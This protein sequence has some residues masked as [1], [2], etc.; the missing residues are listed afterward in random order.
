MGLACPKAIPRLPGDL[1]R[2]PFPT[3]LVAHDR[4]A[5]QAAAAQAA[6][7]SAHVRKS[8]RTHARG[9]VVVLMAVSP[10]PSRR[11]FTRVMRVTSVYPT[12]EQAPRAAATR[13]AIEQATPRV[14][15]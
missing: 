13:L 2:E 8:A 12:S 11:E 7:R 15:T 9:V 3:A 4:V 1:D 5:A 10:L 14:R 6:F